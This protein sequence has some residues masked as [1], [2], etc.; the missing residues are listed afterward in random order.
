MAMTNYQAELDGPSRVMPQ[1]LPLDE[2][3]NDVDYRSDDHGAE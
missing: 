1:S 3:Q 2:F